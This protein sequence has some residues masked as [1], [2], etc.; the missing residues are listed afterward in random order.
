MIKTISIIGAGNLAQCLIERIVACKQNYEILVYDIDK[1]KNKYSSKKNIKFFTNIN[2]KISESQ[3]IL[4]AIKPNDMK[5]ISDD[6]VKY[7]DKR[8]MLISLIAGTRLNMI[9]KVFKKSFYIARIMTN[10]NSQF[11]NAQSFIFA[12]T[13]FS[14]NKL[15]SLEYFFK[16]FGTTTIVK[17]ESQIDKITALCGS[18]PAYFIYF[19]EIIKDTF[20]KFGFKENEAEQLSK[21]LFYSTSYTCFYK[22]DSMKDIKK[23]IVSKKG[24]T[25]AALNMMTKKNIKKIIMDS[26]NQAYEKSIEIGKNK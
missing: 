25:E 4:L 23:M 19:T 11:G 16:L 13:N 15:K 7:G 6:I 22:K 17:R 3:I 24:T 18:G 8:S 20:K 1:K 9:N 2:Q 14:Q 26:I 12:G 5:F 21:H 10:I